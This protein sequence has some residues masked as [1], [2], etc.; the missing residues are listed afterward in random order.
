MSTTNSKGED[1]ETESL[2]PRSSTSLTSDPPFETVADAIDTM[3]FGKFNWRLYFLCGMGNFIDAAQVFLMYILVA[4]LKADESWRL[5]NWQVAGVTSATY[6]GMLLGALFLGKISDDYGRRPVF[7]YAMLFAASFELVSAVAPSI[8]WLWVLRFAQ[9]CIYGG[10]VVTDTVLLAEM[11]PKTNRGTYI[12]SLKV[13]YGVGGLGT[14]VLAYLTI[15]RLG[16]RYY[17][18][19]NAF[20]AVITALLRLSIPESPHWQV[21]RGKYDEAKQGLLNIA[22]EN[23]SPESVK[24]RIRGMNFSHDPDA[25]KKSKGR[26][27]DFMELFD[28]LLIRV[29]LSLLGIWFLFSFA[30]VLAQWIPLYLQQMT[31]ARTGKSGLAGDVYVSTGF[32]AL[33]HFIGGLSLMSVIECFGRRKVLWGVLLGSTTM[34]FVLAFLESEPSAILFLQF[35]YAIFRSCVVALLYT[36]TPECYPTEIRTTS[37]GFLNGAFRIGPALGTWVV[38]ELLEFSFVIVVLS[39]TAVYAGAFV[40]AL[41]VPYDTENRAL[42][43]NYYKDRQEHEKKV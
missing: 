23:G 31:K 33:G 19:F 16:W 34:C 8:Y 41:F 17:L 10:S 21:L 4:S 15:P 18:A 20:P 2:I 36:I 24:A 13:F 25:N 14:V 9:G 1:V 12:T 28:P 39:L 11:I 26:C 38:A 35:P 40:S 6:I 7:R 32:A 30:S 37:L 5:H 22:E 3:G 29:T 43:S 27:S 42:A